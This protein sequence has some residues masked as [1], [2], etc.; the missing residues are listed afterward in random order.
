MWDRNF[1][2]AF[3][4][5]LSVYLV[6]IAVAVLLIPPPEA[7]VEERV[8]GVA[9]D[10]YRPDRE[11]DLTA[12]VSLTS[13]EEPAVFLVGFYPA[14]ARLLVH[15]LP[16]EE[17]FGGRT[18]GEL[19]R[20]GNDALRSAV[21]EHYGIQV[22]CCI[23][24]GDSAAQDF[25]RGLGSVAVELEED[26]PVESGGQTVTLEAGRQLLDSGL[27]VRVLHTHPELAEPLF[28]AWCG[29]F[30]SSVEGTDTAAILARLQ[31]GFE[32]DL[33]YDM[34]ARRVQGMRW[35]ARSGEEYLVCVS[36]AEPEEVGRLFRREADAG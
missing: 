1:W 20:E 32:T 15:A 12:L 11:E 5:S 35:L 6:G 9:F 36:P 30:F 28:A 24:G 19:L 10:G 8:S 7:P 29:L 3:G 16:R 34:L 17:E 22:D 25:V 31:D 23:T 27:S 18:A 33:T 2:R 13:G 4:L 14:D 26:T 21:E